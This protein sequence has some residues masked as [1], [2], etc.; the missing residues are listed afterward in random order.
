[1]SHK[2]IKKRTKDDYKRISG[3]NKCKQQNMDKKVFI[4]I[5]VQKLDFKIL[6]RIIMD[7]NFL[8]SV[9]A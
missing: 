4:Q 5:P 1:M 8:S 9:T 3:M 7:C 6:E 2:L